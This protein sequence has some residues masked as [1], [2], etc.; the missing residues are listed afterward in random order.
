MKITLSF[1]LDTA[2]Y[3]IA[4][5]FLFFIPL[6]FYL[7]RPAAYVLSA[8]FAIIFTLFTIKLSLNKRNKK[9]SSAEKEKNYSAIMTTLNLA[10]EKYLSDLFNAAFREEGY[11]TEKKHGGIFIAEKN[12]TVFMRFGFDGVTKTDVVKC[13][14]KIPKPQKAEIYSEKF[15]DEVKD[16]AARF[17]GKIILTDGKAA[18]DLLEKHSLLPKAGFT[19]QNEDKKPA[20]D[21][22]LLLNKKRAKSYLAFGLLFVFLSYFAPIKGYYLTFGALFLIFSLVLKLFGKTAAENGR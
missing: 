9:F 15:S 3:F 22:S 2:F 11:V 1:I 5:F 10:D 20:V 8:T 21:F 13:F 7:P 12:K 19:L 17:G 18:F 14:N 16:F 6:N 4:G